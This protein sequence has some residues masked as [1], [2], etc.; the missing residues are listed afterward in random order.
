MTDLVQPLNGGNFIHQEGPGLSCGSLLDRFSLKGKTAVVTGAGGGIGL[1]VA[2]AFA[3]L[4]ANVAIWYNS[5]ESAH[6]RAKDISEKYG[7]K[8]KCRILQLD[9][10]DGLPINRETGK[11]FK[12]NIKDYASV[13]QALDDQ[14]QE[15]N[16]R[17]DVFVANAGIPWTK[18]PMINGPVEHY[19]DVV[20]TDLDS[21][22]FCAR[23]AAQHWKRQKQEGTDLEGRQLQN[24][25]S[26]SFIA[27]ASMSGVIVNVPQL[28]AAYNAAKAGVIHLCKSLAVEWAQF[29][30]AN[31]VSP[32]YIITE[33][34]NFVPQETKDIWKDKIPLG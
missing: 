2:Q 30:R 7:V 18:G 16:G 6:D 14:V 31:S 5:N 26:G 8:C 23:A 3:E 19:S 29:A 4:G 25:S 17:L 24:F 20:A 1:S 27:T 11:A 10:Y 9:P 12:V 33:I 21:T 13:E 34:S 32:G 22:Y 28:Q 15:F